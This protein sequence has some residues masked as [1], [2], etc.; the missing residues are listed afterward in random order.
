MKVVFA[1]IPVLHRGYRDLLLAHQDADELWIYGPELIAQFDY[2]RKEIRA[3]SPEDARLLLAAW[4]IIPNVRIATLAMIAELS[5]RQGVTIVMPHDDVSIMMAATHLKRCQILYHQIFLRWDQ[6]N[7]AT[8]KPVQPDRIASTGGVT[9]DLMLMALTEGARS[10]DQWRQIGVLITQ[11]DGTILFIDHNQHLPTSNTPLIDGDARAS[12]Y[13]GVHLEHATSIHAEAN[14]IAQAAR[15]GRSIDGCWMFSTDFPCP[16][17]AK[18]I[19]R[20]GIVKL[21]Y[22][23]GYAIFDG[24]KILRDHGVEI[25]HLTDDA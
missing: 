19:A 5:Q 10:S 14:V 21:Y 11:P 13:K 20:S 3:L 17:C 22:R 25:I 4:S 16:P 24:E 8:I 18:L 2:L 9:H 23:T 7:T 1:Y 12:F 6:V 15:I